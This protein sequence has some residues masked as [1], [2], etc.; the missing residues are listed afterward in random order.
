MIDRQ[1]RKQFL[2]IHAGILLLILLFPLY[3]RLISLIPYRFLRC[4]LHDLL[5]VYC[6]MCGG[7]R[8]FGAMLR[9]QFVESLQWNALVLPL[10]VGAIGW[11]VRALVRLLKG[12]TGIYDLPDWVWYVFWGLL[13]TYLILRNVLLIAF[14]IDPVGDLLSYWHP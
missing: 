14:G 12:K 7:T 4:I 13:I 10:T 8:A 9:L 2:L 1:E 5:H 6:A 11:D 3:S